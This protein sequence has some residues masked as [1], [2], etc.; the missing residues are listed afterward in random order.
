M[1]STGFKLVAAIAAIALGFFVADIFYFRGSNVVLDPRNWFELARVLMVLAA[2]FVAM[3]LVGR[4]IKQDQSRVGRFIATSASAVGSLVANAS[5][6]VPLTF[7]SV[8]FMYLASATD[9]PLMDQTLAAFDAAIGFDW[10]AFLSFTNKQPLIATTL[11]FAYHALGRQ[12]PLLILLL[13]FARRPRLTEFIALLAISSALTATL[14]LFVPAAGAYAYFRPSPTEFGNFT[15][16]AGMWH[17]AELVKLRSGAP[18]DLMI[19]RAEGLVTFPSYHTALGILV[20][21]ALRGYRWLF[22]P[23]A[24]LNGIMIISTLPEGGH[25]LIDVIAGTT[26]GLVSIL[27]VKSIAGYQPRVAAANAQLTSRVSTPK[28]PPST[29]PPASAAP[30][31]P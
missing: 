27:A 7:A 23:V 17:F 13:A 5:L 2:V 6:F 14:M 10:Q 30:S 25:H 22:W 21:Y 16:R 31:P 28:T 8:W 24:C 20:V 18:F 4:R 26:V 9:R 19:T 1:R 12:L 11:V 3:M 29:S 15:A